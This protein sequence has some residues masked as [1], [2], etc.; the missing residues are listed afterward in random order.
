VHDLDF[1]RR[2]ERSLAWDNLWLSDA[3][4][5]SLRSHRR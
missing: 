4:L 5:A 2:L 1:N 3:Q